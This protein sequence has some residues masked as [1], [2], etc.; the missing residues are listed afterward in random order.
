MI[1]RRSLAGGLLILLPMVIVGTIFGWIYDVASGMI[2]PFT[3]PFITTFGLPKVLADLIVVALLVLLCFLIGTLVATRLGA[4]L[5]QRAEEVLMVRVPGYRSVREIT[6][7]LLGN[8]ND[9]PFK[10]GEVAR[11]WLY[12]KQVDVS[13]LGLVTSRHADG[14]VSVFVPTGPN[15]TTGFIYHVSM[16]L[17]E[18]HP[19]IR[20]EQMMKTVIACGAGTSALFATR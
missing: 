13:V 15:P 2:S 19:E 4:W 11:I 5:W 8:S 7:Q 16:D 1:V 18:L 10:R 17:V 20:V 9:S 12:G 3:G 6:A 14:R